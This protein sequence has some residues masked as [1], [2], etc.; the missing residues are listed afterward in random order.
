MPSRIN[1]FSYPGFR[2]KYNL[3]ELKQ[4]LKDE[5]T[6]NILPFWM[7]KMK[8]DEQGGFYGRIKGDGQLVPDVR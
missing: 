8:D 6:Q 5:L 7:E 3:L 4:Q 2:M 1:S